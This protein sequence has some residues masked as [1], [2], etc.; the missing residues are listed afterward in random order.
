MCTL[1]MN[2]DINWNNN[3]IKTTVIRG[4]LADREVDRYVARARVPIVY[5]A[6][7]INVDRT[8]YDWKSFN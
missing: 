2:V 6:C 5:T 4:S 1:M 3:S 8:I 7:N